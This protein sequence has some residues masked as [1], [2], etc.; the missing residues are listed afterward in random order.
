MA[1][2]RVSPER[3]WV[4]RLD[5]RR[6][7]TRC[8]LRTRQI[9]RL[10][11]CCWE[12]VSRRR[13]AERDT[14]RLPERRG[15]AR[16]RNHDRKGL[17]GPPERARNRRSARLSR[18]SRGRRH[19]ARYRHRFPRSLRVT[20][21][22]ECPIWC[23]PDHLA[24]LLRGSAARYRRDC[25]RCRRGPRTSARWSSWGGPSA[26]GRVPVGRRAECLELAEGIGT[27]RLPG[28]RAISVQ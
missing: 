3:G 17:S 4:T 23:T 26:T 13:G 24:D 9:R 21:A 11:P 6:L 14:R 12:A 19:G 2:A 18:L 1:I 8:L 22:V 20:S 28:G 7:A 25:C 16:A 10:A 27:P 15:A 5:A